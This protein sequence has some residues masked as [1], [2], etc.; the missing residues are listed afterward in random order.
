MQGRRAPWPFGGARLWPTNPAPAGGGQT[1]AA[2]GSFCRSPVIRAENGRRLSHPLEFFYATAPGALRRA[3]ARGRAR[4]FRVRR[5]RGVSPGAEGCL[6]CPTEKITDLL[7]AW[8]GGDR[9]ALDRLIPLV[10]R[11]LRLLAR[12]HMRREGPS[13][14][15]QTTALVNEV[16]LKLV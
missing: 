9:L 10:E 1:P 2:A 16:Y 14:T 12:R 6:M 4:I 3:G 7:V 8:S 11:E 13:H 15:L 5:P